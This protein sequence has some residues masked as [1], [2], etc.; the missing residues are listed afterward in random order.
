MKMTHR[1][2]RRLEGLGFWKD[3]A[4]ARRCILTDRARWVLKTWGLA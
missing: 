2:S 4:Y 3:A 1:V